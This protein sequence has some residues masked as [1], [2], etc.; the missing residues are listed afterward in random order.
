MLNSRPLCAISNDKEVEIL[1]PAHFLI[2]R[3]LTIVPEVESEGRHKN[4]TARW[5]VVKKVALHFW[6]RW[7]KDYLTTLQV[8]SKWKENSTNLAINDIVL[9]KDDNQPP[10]CWP[11][12]KVIQIHPG[13]DS[14]V[15]VVTLKTMK[16]SLQRPVAKLVKLPIS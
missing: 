11:L 8:R 1:T 15:R 3:P 9:I 16:G 10:T 5:E 4:L 6:R 2:H 7:H 13:T 12:G 14:V